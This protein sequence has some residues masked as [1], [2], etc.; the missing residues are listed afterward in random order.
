MRYLL[1]LA[2][3]IFLPFSLQAKEHEGE[4]GVA[5]VEKEEDVEKL[6]VLGSH[7]K[8]ITTEGPSPVLVID[9]E[10]IEMSGYNSLGDVL[11]ELPVASLGGQR[12][13]S[14]NDISLQTGTSLR[15][16]VSYNIL[17]LINGARVSPVGG[18]S[19]V[20]LNIIPLSVIERVEILKEGTPIYGSDAIGGVINI[21]TK[22]GDVGGQV[23]VQGSLV[24]REEGIEALASFLDFWNWND[25]GHSSVD[26]SW[27]GKGDTLTVD[28][29]YGGSKNDINYMVG[30]QLRFDAPMYLRD[31]EFGKPKVK[32]YSS[33]GSP[34]TWTDDGGATWNPAPGCPTNNIKNGRCKFDYS[35]FMQ[36]TPQIFQTSGFLQ[37]SK[38]INDMTVSGRAIYN[39]TKAHSILAPAP[40]ATVFP[41]EVAQKWGLSTSNDVFT[42]YRLVEEEGA[43]PREHITNQH[44]YQVQLG[45]IKP[46]LNTLEF[47]LEFNISGAHYFNTGVEGYAIKQNP[48]VKNI[49]DE[50]AGEKYENAKE[51]VE[52]AK[53]LMKEEGKTSLVDLAK[54]GKFNIIA[55]KKDDIS[56]AIYE[57]YTNTNSNVI[58]LEPKLTGE[59]AEI[60]GQPLLFALGALGAW[61]R[62]NQSSD[63]FSRA[64]VQWGGGVVDEGSGN[65]FSGGLYGEISSIFVD[66]IE[67]Q[68]GARTDYYYSD[69]GFSGF[70]MQVFDDG[71]I[72]LPFSP[73]VA[74]S[75]QPIDEVKLRTSWGLGFKVP[76]LLSLHH[77]KKVSY[78]FAID[79]VLCPSYD[80]DKDECAQTQFATTTTSNE[81]LDPEL[82]QSFNAGITVEPVQGISFGIDYYRTIQENVISNV[83]DNESMDYL[84][85]SILKYEQ[86]H[87]VEKLRKL[88]D[89]DVKRNEDGS[90]SEIEMQLINMKN[91]EV[92]GLDLEVSFVV[93][94]KDGWDLGIGFEHSHLL[95]VKKQLFE[96]L[97]ADTPVPHYEW[98]ADLF[99]LDTPEKE[100]TWYGFPRWRNRAVLSVM[101]K[102]MGHNVQ[103]V[104]HN[105]PS[106]LKLPEGNEEIEYYW[107]LD[108]AGTA[109]LTKATSLTVGI[110]N[111]LGQER[112]VNMDHHKNSGYI[113]SSL[114]SIRGRA[115]DARLSYNF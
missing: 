93:P 75:F 57:P 71:E 20:D 43:G 70:A 18:D 48:D 72:N 73:R 37:A 111:I 9:R 27:A 110:R 59:I 92:Q 95:Y 52:E 2:L 28:A 30:G 63:E 67:V 22:K 4:S 38:D 94:L 55:D 23:N 34:G 35:P 54:Q 36:F 26:N 113:H 96:E 13:A 47:E 16:I 60:D 107:Q 45:A 101:N 65:R 86:K 44:F 97:D 106:Q 32:H 41:A 11:R 66:M 114:Y 40:D 21:V 115:I 109:A 7:I 104:V 80:E 98:V 33:F 5:D 83:T 87:G 24:Q 68:L 105:I 64:G 89:F 85:R 1:F 12:A 62:Y 88:G 108:L 19:Y 102:D 84:L 29:S 79:H 99:G 69:I 53:E 77:Q 91:Y 31:R 112:P 17:V 58:S 25:T 39:Y 56:K 81:D 46:F 61:Q 10:Q 49:T 42:F 76:T 50:T 14:L 90:V 82:S 8:K 74:L 15:G 3:F 103:I 6:E 51:S 78:P 100:E